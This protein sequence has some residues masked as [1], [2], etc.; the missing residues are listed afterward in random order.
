[1]GINKEKERWEVEAL[2]TRS[3]MELQA[4]TKKR[5]GRIKALKKEV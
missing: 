4:H 1:M 3:V 5:K 2:E